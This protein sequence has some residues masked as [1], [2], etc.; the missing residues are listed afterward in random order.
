[1]LKLFG[2]SMVLQVAAIIA[3]TLLL[4]VRPLLAPPVMAADTGDGILFGLITEW[5][6]PM[7]LLAV[8]TAIILVVAGGVV[9]NLMLADVGLTPQTSLLPTLL[10]IIAMSAPATTLTPPMLANLALMACAN[11]LLLRG[12]LLTVPT[13]KICNATALI[14]LASMFYTPAIAMVAFYL[15][16]VISYRLYN[17]R[18]WAA[19]LLGLAA[20]YIIL[21]AVLF[22]ADGLGLWWQ[23]AMD[24]FD[25]LR[26]GTADGAA[27]AAGAVLAVIMVASLFALWGR[28][29]ENIV[30]WQKNATVVMLL[31]VGG[32]ATSLCSQV[33]PVNFGWYAISFALCGTHLFTPSQSRHKPTK[34]IYGWF[35]DALFIITLASALL[36]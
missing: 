31:F 14:G 32:I 23:Q 28:L 5:L 11:Q 19:L 29:G 34:K 27:V 6:Q 16:I 15:L 12:T 33:F 1:M 36:C 35:L 13:S 22:M 26:I 24:S 17:W 18:D 20:P 4:W 25:G 10:Y 9:L 21:A 8:I 7:P 3:A 30:V 2:K